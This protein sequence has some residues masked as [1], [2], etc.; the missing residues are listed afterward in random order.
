[1]TE[2]GFLV[3]ESDHRAGQQECRQQ[4]CEYVGC[5]IVL[6]CQKSRKKECFNHVFP[7]FRRGTFRQIVV[8]LTRPGSHRAFMTRMKSFVET[9]YILLHSYIVFLKA[10]VNRK[11]TS[12]SGREFSGL[13]RGEIR[14]IGCP[15]R[16]AVAVRES[17]KAHDSLKDVRD[18]RSE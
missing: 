6:D 4:T 8:T 2:N 9:H 11:N 5:H 18:D 1:M 12:R 7:A 16:A 15:D 14:V 13:H 3:D 10:A 17:R